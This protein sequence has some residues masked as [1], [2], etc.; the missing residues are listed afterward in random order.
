M[1]MKIHFLCSQLDYFP[2]NCGNYNEEQ[3]ERSHQDHRQMEERY[4][5]YWNINMLADY[6]ECLKRDLPNFMHRR[7]SLK[8]H[9]L[10]SH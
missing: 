8:R 4:Q 1:S 6:C 7:K 5:R 10:S 3:G 9:F 2:D